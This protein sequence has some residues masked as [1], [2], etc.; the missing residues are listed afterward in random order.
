M[1][2]I[3]QFFVMLM[4]TNK[5]VEVFKTSIDNQQESTLVGNV[6]YVMYPA[7]KINF[8]LADCDRILRIENSTV[9]VESVTKIVN[10]LGH[11]CEVLV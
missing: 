4:E 9:S 1:G 8:D 6:L 3:G 2:T 7:A 10:A 11:Q 5:M